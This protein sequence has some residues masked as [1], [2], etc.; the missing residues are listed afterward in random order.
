MILLNGDADKSAPMQT[1][2]VIKGR[3]QG[4]FFRVY[5]GQHASKLGLK[6]YVQNLKDGSVLAVVQGDPERVK[7]LIKL[8]RVGPIMA[9]IVS[10]EQ[11]EVPAEDVFAFSDIR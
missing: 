7:T 11:S 5:V 1:R 4:V 6:G 3:V 8:C 9:K 10:V 2:I